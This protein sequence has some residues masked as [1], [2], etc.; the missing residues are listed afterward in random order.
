MRRISGGDDRG[1]VAILVALF[2]VVMFM[3]GALVVDLGAAR[4][5][6][7]DAQNAAD[8]SAL[9]GTDALYPSGPTP[10]FSGAVAAVK[11]YA[12]SNLGTTD[13]DW[14]ACTTTQ[15]LAYTPSGTTKCISFDSATSPVNVRV[16][17]PNSHVSSFFGG[18]VGYHGMDITA[19]AQAQVGAST[20]PVCSFCVLGSGMHSVQNGN[21]S[22]QDGDIWTNGS[23]TIGSNGALSSSGSVYVHGTV[24]QPSRVTGTLVQNS[25]LVSDPLSTLAMPSTTGLLVKTD[26]CSQGPGRYGAVSMSSGGTCTLAAGLYV[27]TDPLS[28]GGSKTFI[29]N[30]VTLFFTCGTGG[31]IASCFG[32]PTPG[33]LDQGGSG[34][35][36]LTAP[37]SGALKGLT[38]V[39]DRG[40]TAGINLHGSGTLTLGGTI[41]ASAS[42]F[43]IKGGSC[44]TPQQTMVV[45]SDV[46]FAGNGSCFTTKYV[47]AINVNL[48][49]DTGL[50]R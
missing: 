27:F 43:T 5:T 26:P 39:Y 6:R 34:A 8:A 19:L 17:V 38:V 46:A 37:T 49:G 36:T 21:L 10:D 30:G 7:R 15:N 22:I 1:A 29:A 40:D 33:S 4:V 25:D 23:V 28:I 35:F 16:I 2:S 12:S 20:R 3:F 50:V 18:V 13:S 31:I 14:A 42:T 41:Y 11:S 9:A 32:D 48:P 24:D 44:L 45:V 47:P